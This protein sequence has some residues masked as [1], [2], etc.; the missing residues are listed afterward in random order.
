MGDLIPVELESSDL[1]SV[2]G[3]K[4]LQSY[5]RQSISLGPVGL[6]AYPSGA[7][8]LETAARDLIGQLKSFT[9]VMFEW[10]VRFDHGELAKEIQALGVPCRR[11]VVHALRIHGDYDRSFAGF[12]STT[13][14]LI[15][16]TRREGLVV[17]RSAQAQDVN[18][19]YDLYER[20]A[21]TKHRLLYPRS[22]FEQLLK[23]EEDVLF[24]V[25]QGYNKLIGGA[26]F[27]RDGDTALYW[28]SEMDVQYAK[29]SPMYAILD[30][31]IRMAHEEGRTFFNFGASSGLPSLEQFKAKW[32]AE[33]QYGWHF[34]WVNPL[35]QAVHRCKTGLRAYAG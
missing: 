22:V 12:N 25:A 10:N 30:C 2:V 1:M 15:R 19:Y 6:Y 17:R 4:R 34:N 18:A 20:V 9:T 5:G 28:H 29:Q 33:P 31:A 16:R 8:E 13:R 14:N 32:G 24:V 35:W 11:T 21:R 23:L 27:F 3:V 26:W 7:G